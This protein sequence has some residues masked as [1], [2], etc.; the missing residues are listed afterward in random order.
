MSRPLELY[1]WHEQ[2]AKHFPGL[3]KPMVLSLALWSLGM[4]VVRSCGLSA[5]AF[6]WS[7]RLGQP[8]HTARER[9]RDVYRE[10]GAKAGT[11]RRQLDVA[12]CWAPWLGWVLEGWSGTRPEV[13]VVPLTAP[14]ELE[15]EALPGG[16]Q[17]G[18]GRGAAFAEFHAG[19]A[20]DDR[21]S[22][23]AARGRVNAFGGIAPVVF[24]IDE[25][26]QPDVFIR[27]FRFADGG[28][29][30]PLNRGTEK[31]T[32]GQVGAG[33]VVLPIFLEHVGSVVGFRGQSHQVEEH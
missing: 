3:G 4:I 29:Y 14:V 8:F 26:S 21:L 12:T 10:A 24:Q 25:G 18:V 27:F 1:Q 16:R 5:V 11:R 30:Q 22:D 28:G 31:G 2:I 13:E 17:L 20:E 6:W 9:L 19:D 7:C 23:I 33:G 15:F 32:G